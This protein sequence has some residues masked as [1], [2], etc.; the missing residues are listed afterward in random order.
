MRAPGI[1]PVLLTGATL[2]WSTSSAIVIRHD[3]DEARHRDLARSFTM[4]CELGGGTGTLIAPRWVLTA[5]HVAQGLQRR[6]AP[7]RF[8]ERELA[9]DAIHLHPKGGSGP[10]EHDIAL[11][12]LAEPVEGILPAL[13]P[14]GAPAVGDTVTF[15]GNGY[16]GTGTD[17]PVR[18][19]RVWRAAHNQLAQLAPGV[20][21]FTFDSPPGGLELEGI[22]GPGDSGGPALV[23]SGDG[24]AIVGVS[25]ANDGEPPCRYGSR[26]YYASVAS[27][28]DWIRATMAAK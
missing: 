21:V 5:A 7:A 25:S 9:I 1:L 19:E 22:S 26:E 4:A 15:V 28:L 6:P 10:G 20:L 16:T 3:R 8:G 17:G 27:V 14:T 13:L 2:W 11:I 12:R 23:P 24:W 18:G